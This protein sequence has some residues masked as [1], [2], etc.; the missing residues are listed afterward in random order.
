MYV[1]MYVFVFRCL[2]I[3]L[4]IG[5]CIFICISI[6]LLDL[7]SVAHEKLQAMFHVHMD[8]SVCVYT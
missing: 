3:Y 6:Y 1:C 2:H 4:S 5:V 8:V 7:L